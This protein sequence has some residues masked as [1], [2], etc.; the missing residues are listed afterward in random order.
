MLNLPLFLN[1][2]KKI[3]FVPENLPIHC[4]KLTYHRM[5]DAF[6][7]LAPSTLESLMEDFEKR[8]KEFEEAKLEGAARFGAKDGNV[9]HNQSSDATVDSFG[10]KGPERFIAKLEWHVFA[11]EKRSKEPQMPFTAAG[12][13]ILPVPLMHG[14]DYICYGFLFGPR[15]ACF[16]YL[17]DVK[18]F[19]KE[20][21]DLLLSVKIEVLVIDA[22]FVER[23]HTTH[24][25]Y[26]EALAAIRLLKPKRSIL[27]GMTH[28]FDYTAF[29]HTLEQLYE[30]EGIRVDMGY[31]GLAV[32]IHL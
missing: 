11:D 22:L 1:Q 28:E 14:G 5:R 17:S 12:L 18:E 19:P 10:R 15:D 26:P 2:G 23:E 29:S 9:G 31:D 4:S 13:E 21:L 8:Q 16:A 6:R 32:D 27:T 7:Y 30:K 24:F 20:T 25:S 3:R